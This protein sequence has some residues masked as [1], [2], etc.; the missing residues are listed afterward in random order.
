MENEPVS[1]KKKSRADSFKAAAI[2]L[3]FYILLFVFAGSIVV[4]R[5]IQKQNAE[6][7]VST[8]SA[9]QER[10]SRQPSANPEKASET[11]LPAT[12]IVSRAV[13]LSAPAFVAPAADKPKTT[14]S[15]K[16]S[17]P[18]AQS[19]RD[20]GAIS[21]RFGTGTPQVEF[22]GI[23]A[24]GEKFVFVIDASPGMLAQETGGLPAYDYIKETLRKTV[25]KMPAA[26]LYNVVLYDGE[27]I[28]QFR[29]QPIPATKQN[30][31]VLDEWLR[32]VNRDKA[33]KGLTDKQ[34]NYRRPSAPYQTAVGTEATS[35]LLALQS[36]FEQKADNV[37]ILSSDWGRHSIGPGKRR[38]LRDFSLWEELGGG[39]AFS[40]GGSPALR[41]DRKL[42]DDLLKQA[43]D[44]IKKEEEY[45]KSE[46]LP[47]EF[48]PDVPAY[49]EYPV[50]QILD[51]AEVVCSTQYAPYQ[52]ER[53]Q[54]HVVRMISDDKYGVA[55]KSAEYMQQLTR[56]YNGG[57]ESFSGQQAASRH[58]DT[59]PAGKNSSVAS[60]DQASSASRK[61]DVPSSPVQFL[62]ADAVGSRIAFILD[63]SSG[64]LTKKTGGTNTYAAVKQR[65]LK[66]V[67]EMSP[68]TLFNVIVYDRK[69][70]ALFRSQMVPASQSGALTGW[71]A[72]LNSSTARS[73]LRPEQNSYTPR[74]VYET[75]ISED[76]QSLPFA[77]QAA[78]EEQADTIFIVST[79]MG[80]QPVNPVK[81]SRLLDFYI[82][83]S[84]GGASGSASSVEEDE[85]GEITV[86]AGDSGS[87]GG[88]LRL[89][90]EDAK[91]AGALVK[92]TLN[93]IA[94]DRKARKDAG[95]P[96]DFVPDI[97][98]SIQYTS[99]QVQAHIGAVCD[100][101]YVSQELTPPKIHFICLQETGK[102]PTKEALRDLRG[103]TEPYNGTVRSIEGSDVAR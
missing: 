100:V 50:A 73:G 35:W 98:N 13:S 25:A 41:D 39:G 86:V 51:H 72:D 53:P 84:L 61:P 57:F 68:E 9:K 49:I 48:L 6:F 91:M 75:A 46:A 42:R 92:Q 74:Q 16:F 19:G 26:V 78:M 90:K 52:L 93:Q 7:T 40:I 54:V 45:R 94:A 3:V 14:S 82:W 1:L 59:V 4:V 103:L 33:H 36:A 69:Q 47:A 32:P 87:T 44:K 71:L 24:E 60:I 83:N 99:A 27:N 21:K 31:A 70:V 95:L 23:R 63:A 37:F 58:L 56:K 88:T 85:E 22:F 64:M 80:S 20:Y 62:R 30:N 101:N 28:F 29:P 76:V 102:T 65:L 18:A 34:N 43:V 67:E 77:L 11:P 66:A 81:A 12:K 2:T 10:R 96:L 8:G 97:L 55:D 79:G 15:Q 5:Y 17:L 38:L 89:L